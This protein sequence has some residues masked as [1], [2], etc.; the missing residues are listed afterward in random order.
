LKTR[1]LFWWQ[2]VSPADSDYL[3]TKDRLT[4]VWVEK[5]KRKEK[6]IKAGERRATAEVPTTDRKGFVCWNLSKKGEH[7]AGAAR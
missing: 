4:L 7:P 2:A 5:V 3:R 6:L 1:H